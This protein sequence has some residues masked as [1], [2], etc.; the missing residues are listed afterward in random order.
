LFDGELKNDEKCQAEV[1][2]LITENRVDIH[3]DAELHEACGH[4]IQDSICR[5][6]T[7]GS[8]RVMS[9]LLSLYDAGTIKSKKCIDKVKN[10]KELWEHAAKMMRDQ[11]LSPPETL[12]QVW[13]DMSTSSSRWYFFSV[14]LGVLAVILVLGVLCGRASKRLAAEIKDR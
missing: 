6:V 3:T 9:C 8:G 5:S 14:I 7:A 2:R 13:E 12:K 4:D 11:N 10:R 1:F